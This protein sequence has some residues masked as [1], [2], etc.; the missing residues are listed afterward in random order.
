MQQ[1]FTL[2]QYGGICRQ[3]TKDDPIT[4]F[5]LQCRVEN[6]V[7]KGE[8]AKKL[9]FAP[10]P[11]MFSKA[12]FLSVVKSWGYAVKKLTLYQMTNF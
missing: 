12:V 3:Q 10:F 8:N 4:R 11:T 1:N 2:V 5:P 6:T 9:A 7:G